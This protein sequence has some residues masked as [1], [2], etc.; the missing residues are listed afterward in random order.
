MVVVVVVVVSLSFYVDLK[1][2]NYIIQYV[3]L[4]DH[5]Y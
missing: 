4:N 5:K 3:E 1:Y 2:Y